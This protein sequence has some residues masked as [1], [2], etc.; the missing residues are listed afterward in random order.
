V[1]W[2]AIGW[3]LLLTERARLRGAAR[4]PVGAHEG[5]SSGV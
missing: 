3:I 2:I 4:G 5:P 1:V